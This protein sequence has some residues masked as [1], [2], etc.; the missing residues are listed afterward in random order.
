MKHAVSAE[1][2]LYDR[3]FNVENPDDSQNPLDYKEYLNPDSL[4]I[5][6]DA[7]LE[8]ALKDGKVGEPFQF[9]RIGYFCL[10]KESCPDHLVFNRTASLRDSWGKVTKKQ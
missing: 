8:P 10:D 3:L 6:A 9:E 7:K 1:V 4:E 5:I 2:R